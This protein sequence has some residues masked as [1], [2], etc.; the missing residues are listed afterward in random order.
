MGNVV[1][2]YVSTTRVRTDDMTR[3]GD[4]ISLGDKLGLMRSR[5]LH[6]VEALTFSEDEARESDRKYSGELLSPA[7]TNTDRFENDYVETHAEQQNEENS[8][9]LS[10]KRRHSSRLKSKSEK[11]KSKA[12]TKSNE[13]G[14]ETPDSSVNRKRSVKKTTSVKK[15]K[16]TKKTKSAKS[17]SQ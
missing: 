2:N 10:P 1:S 11:S 8:N 17:K 15:D 5:F 6:T 14:E 3:T 9:A 7:L 16:S 4:K 13:D 12:K